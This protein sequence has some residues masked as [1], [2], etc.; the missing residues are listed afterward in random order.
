MTEPTTLGLDS[1]SGAFDHLATAPILS[2]FI[3]IIIGFMMFFPNEVFPPTSFRIPIFTE[4]ASG[5]GSTL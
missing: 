3:S 2:S 1:L 5:P 4:I